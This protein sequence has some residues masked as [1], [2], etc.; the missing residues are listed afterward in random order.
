M[1][2]IHQSLEIARD[3]KHTKWI[4]PLLVTA[5]VAL[6]LLIVRYVPCTNSPWH[7]FPINTRSI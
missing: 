3:P 6:C 2:L 4:C 7:P 5:E 1:D